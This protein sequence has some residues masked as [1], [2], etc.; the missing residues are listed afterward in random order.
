KRHSSE[1]S[2]V[3]AATTAATA[4]PAATTASSTAASTSNRSID[5]RTIDWGA[6]VPRS[7]GAEAGPLAGVVPAAQRS[8]EIVLPAP[9]SRDE[10]RERLEA[11]MDTSKRERIFPRDIGL[12]PSIVVDETDDDGPTDRVEAPSPDSTSTPRAT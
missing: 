1:P 11:L 12:E 9:P 3:A 4:A 6:L 5:D 7:V 8:G 10:P 2:P